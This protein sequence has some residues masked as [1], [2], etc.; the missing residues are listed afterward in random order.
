MSTIE[1][2]FIW[3]DGTREWKNELGNCHRED[4]DPDTGET[5]PAVIRANGDKWWYKDGNCHRDDKD[6]VTG[7]TLPA[8]ILA[9]GNKTWYK[10]GK[11]HR[12]DKDFNTDETLP[13]IIRAD[14]T[15][16]WYKDGKL[17][18]DDKDPVMGETL[19]A[20]IWARG[21]KEWWKNGELHRDDK[22]PVTGEILP[23]I[24]YACGSKMWYKDGKHILPPKMICTRVPHLLRSYSENIDKCYS[25]I[26]YITQEELS[27]EKGDDILLLPVDIGI[28]DNTTCGNTKYH[29]FTR[30]EVEMWWKGNPERTHP[31]TRAPLTSTEK[32]MIVTF[33]DDDTFFEN[34]EDSDEK[35]ESDNSYD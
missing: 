32:N 20:V 8:V 21:N 5:L 1:G 30:E 15:R 27:A 34:E 25:N 29:C 23:A 28:T 35:S 31:V 2:C 9:C 33:M 10:N 4:K 11:R 22:D 16:E 7:E 13:A 12:D 18:R 3:T 6:P 14:G 17:H 24:I 19:P 26:S